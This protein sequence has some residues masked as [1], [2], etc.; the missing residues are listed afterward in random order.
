MRICALP[1]NSMTSF[2]SIE[3]HSL[4]PSGDAASLPMC[5][6]PS[7]V[8][9][10]PLK[11]AL[12]QR[13]NTLWVKLKSQRLYAVAPEASLPAFTAG[14]EPYPVHY[15]QAFAFASSSTPSTMALDYSQV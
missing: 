13:V 3:C 8:W 5:S 11:T 14:H 2:Q 6:M 10:D 7:P 9:F 4:G 1:T 15:R 12:T